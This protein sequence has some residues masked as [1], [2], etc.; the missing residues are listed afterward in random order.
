MSTAACVSLLRFFLPGGAEAPLSRWQNYYPDR[1]IT[2]GGFTYQAL[3]F[4]VSPGAGARGGERSSQQI[5]LALNDISATLAA[6]ATTG[7]WMAEIETVLITAL[8]DTMVRAYTREMW[9]CSSYR[10]ED[11][12]L[13]L[14]LRSPF[15][16]VVSQFPGRVLTQEMVG[17][18]PSTALV[19]VR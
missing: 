4:L 11:N 5:G 14:E 13:V 16:A 12:G 10:H 18:L 3:P 9:E 8:T 7:G 2:W 1:S 6:Q 17:S 15:D 19:Q